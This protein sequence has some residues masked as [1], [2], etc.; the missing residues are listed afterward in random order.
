MSGKMRKNEAKGNLKEQETVFSATSR[1]PTKQTAVFTT[2]QLISSR[3][4]YCMPTC[5]HS[6][7]NF[8]MYSQVTNHPPYGQNGFYNNNQIDQGFIQD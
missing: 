8:P 6:T 7:L 2:E 4:Y 5:L 1:L 3:N